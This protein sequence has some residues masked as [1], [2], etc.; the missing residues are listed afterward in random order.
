ML[1]GRDL[2]SHLEGQRLGPYDVQSRIGAGGMGEV[3]RARDTRLGR[4]VAIKVLLP[5]AAAGDTSSRERFERE[6]RAVAALNH[7][8]ICTL[9][10]VGI[11]P[12]AGGDSAAVQY[13]VMDTWTVR[14][15]PIAWRR[16]RF[17]SP[18]HWPMRCRSRRRS[19]ART[20]KVSCTA[21]SNRATSC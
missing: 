13:L 1:F 17:P 9:H 19:I 2:G 21:I 20:A 8:H 11:V 6:A 3:Y 16:G 12:E 7:P 15:S 4:T 5:S 10:D 18:T 14:R